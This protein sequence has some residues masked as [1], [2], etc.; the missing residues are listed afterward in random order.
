MRAVISSHALSTCDIKYVCAYREI[1][2]RLLAVDF[3]PCLLLFNAPAL[4]RVQNER[5]IY[6]RSLKMPYTVP[7]FQTFEKITLLEF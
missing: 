7:K 3:S 4:R 1:S 2:S 5:L 6:I